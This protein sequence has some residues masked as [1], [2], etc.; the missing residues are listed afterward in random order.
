MVTCDSKFHSIAACQD[1]VVRLNVDRPDNVIQSQSPHYLSG[2]EL[3]VGRVEVCVG[4]RFGTVC[5][6]FWD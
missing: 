4:G 1:D 3:R 5:D 6:N 2:G